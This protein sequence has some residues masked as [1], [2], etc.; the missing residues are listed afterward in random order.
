MCKFQY[1]GSHTPQEN[2]LL[3]SIKMTEDNIKQLLDEIIRNRNEIKSSIEASE[4]KLLLKIE[5]IINRLNKLEKENFMLKEEIETLKGDNKKN[6]IVIFGIKH[7]GTRLTTEFITE[8]LNNLLDIDLK[9]TD[10]NDLYTLGN[11]EDSPI[12][13]ELTTH[14]KKKLIFQN[15]RKLK[16]TSIFINHDLTPKQ[17]EDNKVLRR[18]LKLAKEDKNKTCYVKKNTLYINEKGYTIEDLLELENQENSEEL[19][20]NIGP[21]TSNTNIPSKYH[22]EVTKKKKEEGKTKV[23][24]NKSERVRKT[25]N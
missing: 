15:C 21:T 9:E 16:D 18:H 20:T 5:G 12:K 10:I 11:T 22:D 17:R 6:N 13:I 19:R 25:R 1:K 24:V 4:S 3:F 2:K 7:Q 8:E 23:L 14:L